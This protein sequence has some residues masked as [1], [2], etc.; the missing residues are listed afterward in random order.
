[1]GETVLYCNLVLSILGPVSALIHIIIKIKAYLNAKKT[2]RKVAALDNDREIAL[3]EGM[4]LAAHDHSIDI[5]KQNV[6]ISGLMP[7]NDVSGSIRAQDLS[8][9]S[10]NNS[11]H[12]APSIKSGQVNTHF[13][14]L[15]PVKIE[16]R[17]PKDAQE[18]SLWIR[19]GLKYF[20][21]DV[22]AA[23]GSQ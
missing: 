12:Y 4:T 11:I 22:K 18:V 23:D 13:A 10:F 5:S 21:G 16:N 1:M 7:L 3:P 2:N 17:R 9:G 8:M 20:D 19:V 15:Q 14:D 6:D